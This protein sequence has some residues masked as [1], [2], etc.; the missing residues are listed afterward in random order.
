MA[1]EFSKPFQHKEQG[2]IFLNGNVLQ[3]QDLVDMCKEHIL[4]PQSAV[5][6]IDESKKILLVTAAFQKGHEHHDRHL[7]ESFEKIGIDAKWKD[8][9]PQNIQ[10][11]SVW[12]TF[13][14]FKYR[15]KWLYQKYTDKQDQ[16]KAFKQDYL[17][18]NSHYVE[19][20]HEIA[21][22]LARTYPNLSIF[23]FY[24]QDKFSS[25]NTLFTINYNK[26]TGEK[27][28]SD[29]ES[30]TN[31]PLDVELCKEL[32][33]VVDHLIFK[34]HELFST[35]QFLEDYFLEKSGILNCALYQ[36]QREEL[37]KRILSSATIFLYGGR[38][39]VLVNRLRFYRLGDFFK[40]AL[41]QKTNLYGISAGTICQMDKFYLNMDRFTPGG[42]LRASDR[43][44]GLVSG[45]W[46]TPHAE[47]YEYIRDA[48]RDALSFFS[49][50]Q[51]HGVTVGLSAK[52]I[53]L[54]EQ[55]R[56]P[57]DSNVYKR[58]T[59][60][61]DEPVLVFGVRGVKHEMKKNAQLILEGTKFYMGKDMVGEEEDI[62]ELERARLLGQE[63]AKRNRN[64]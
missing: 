3:E 62:E 46:V 10:N 48:N 53:L 22:D 32:R 8:G 41:R 63:E 27:I 33:D 19:Q 39:Y 36:E 12:T 9:Y 34:D 31:S 60:I 4:N 6:E 16:I 58:Y 54:V 56:D 64:E 18:K 13:N 20:A 38:V 50:R 37:G 42:Y 7:I 14:E 40:K 55:Y 61:G 47:D 1:N 26:E 28:L 35:C 45:L 21:R 2:W 59:S 25:D 5:P 30:L 51:V 24:H 17:A 43:G 15:E 44:M 52:S 29:L 23:D 49:L 57:I 11:L